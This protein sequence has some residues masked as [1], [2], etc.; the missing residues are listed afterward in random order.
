MKKSHRL[1]GWLIFGFWVVAHGGPLFA[2]VTDPTRLNLDRKLFAVDT[3]SPTW[4]WALGF[5][6]NRAGVPYLLE[7]D[8][9]AFRSHSRLRGKT[10]DE[11][12]KIFTQF[13]V[14][15]KDV[16]LED[17]IRFILKD[18]PNYRYEVVDGFL[19]HIYPVGIEK[20]PDWPLNATIKHFAIE[21]KDISEEWY[22]KQFEGLVTP[23]QVD[24]GT[25]VNRGFTRCLSPRVFE[26]LTLRQLLIELSKTCRY[27]WIFEPLPP[28]EVRVRI[29]DWGDGFYP[30]GKKI[31]SHGGEWFQLTCEPLPTEGVVNGVLK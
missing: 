24:V 11:A 9:L 2:Q 22:R 6:L 8:R 13:K 10:E 21:R 31:E 7:S 19:L 28:E 27:F 26:G 14:H 15:L 4:Q 3:E 1:T 12:E 18:Q 25:I 16:T 17:T 5:V 23:L 20:R 29:Q 30:Q